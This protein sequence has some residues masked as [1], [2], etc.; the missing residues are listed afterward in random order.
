LGLALQESSSIFIFGYSGYDN[1]LNR[2]IE[3]QAQG[4][5]IHIIE[6]SGT[7]KNE[8]RKSFWQDKLKCE[9]ITLTQMENILEFT[10]WN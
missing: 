10:E 6:W 7:G 2:L 5:K 9:N 8:I 4:K 1:H 3:T